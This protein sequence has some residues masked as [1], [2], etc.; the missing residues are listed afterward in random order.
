MATGIQQSWSTT[1]A[2]NANADDAINLREGQAPSTVNNSVREMMAA[3]K[4][5]AKDFS[6]QIVTAGSKA[7][8]TVTTNEGFAALSDGL[9]F[10]ARMHVASGS[11]PTLNVDSLGAK[12]IQVA[13]GVAPSVGKLVKGTIYQFTY[14]SASTVWLVSGVGEHNVG[15]LITHGGATAPPLCLL[16]YGQAVSRT[17]YPALFEV[18]GT[19]HGAGDGSTTFN[20]PD[21]RGRVTAG[22]DDMG[23]S[24]ADRLTN[25]SGGVDGDTL[26]AVGGAE[27][28]SLTS[29]Q[30]GTHSHSVSGTTGGT[31][32]TFTYSA[33]SANWGG[34]SN[35]TIT[36][37]HA[38]SLGSTI[39]TPSHTHSINLTSAESGSGTAHNNVQPTIIQ[40]VYVYAGA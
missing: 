16:A 31:S 6:G 5:M 2:S 7:A 25:A 8:F 29:A 28:H 4:R 32:A 3:I 35:L 36:N 11:A 20:L 18:Y 30:N 26:G 12:A 38:S 19:T 34:G 10:K 21:H 13:V 39:T 17:D 23:G 37:L 1:A 27:T 22:R 15:D 40:N 14:Y 24:S 33:N 9:T